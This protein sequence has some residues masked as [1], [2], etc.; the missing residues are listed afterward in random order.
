M[1]IHYSVCLDALFAGQ[2]IEPSIR[3]VRAAGYSRIEFWA[4][5]QGKDL[6]LLKKACLK[7][8]IEVTAF[9]TRQISLVDPICRQ[10]YIQGLKETLKTAK[11]LE[12]PVIIS[13]VGQDL[14]SDR[15]RQRQSLVD[16]LKACVSILEAAQVTL[17]IEP[18]NTTVDHR[19]YFLTSSDEAFDIVTEVGSPYVKVLFDLYHQQIMEGNLISRV[20]QHLDKIGHIHA[21]GVPGRHELDQGEINYRSVF[22][23]IETC[24]YTGCI[25]LEYFPSEDAEINL[26]KWLSGKAD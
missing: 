16:G 13:Q 18:L 14:G 21:A 12:T 8:G 6:A 20:T 10:D 22:K 23:A 3:A 7:N 15:T 11:Y 1:S 25:G 2:P 5:D 19:G 26:H 17:V 9:C 4:W 24:G